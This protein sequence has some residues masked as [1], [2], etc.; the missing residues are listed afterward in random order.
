MH[1]LVIT[2]DGFLWVA[3]AGND[4]ML[5]MSPGL[6]IVQVLEGAPYDF[7]GPRYQDITDDGLLVVADKY[8]HSIKVVGRDGKLLA[9]IGDGKPGKGP[10]K[11]R[12]PEGVVIRGD[13]AWF[14]DSGNDRIVRYRIMR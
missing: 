3:D 11:F 2:K 10:G 5:R 1:D 6:E 12:T 4:R 7:S 9:V 8:T 13:N 14:S